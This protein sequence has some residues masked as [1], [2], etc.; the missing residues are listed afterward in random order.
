MDSP[1]QRRKVLLEI[2]SKDL[3]DVAGIIGKIWPLLSTTAVPWTVSE[4]SSLIILLEDGHREMLCSIFFAPSKR[5]HEDQSQTFPVVCRASFDQLIKRHPD[6]SA[7]I[8]S[9]FVLH[10]TRCISNIWTH[11]PRSAADLYA[12]VFRSAVS[13]VKPV[14]RMIGLIDECVHNATTLSCFLT[15]GYWQDSS[16]WTET[17]ARECCRSANLEDGHGPPA[18]HLQRHHH[19]FTQGCSLIFPPFCSLKV[20][21]SFRRPAA[22]TRRCARTS[23]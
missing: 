23:S 13:V 12:W 14:S 8:L 3:M 20:G 17:G 4:L 10:F 15:M 21:R 16:A 19:A 7:T 6:E 1:A 22:A 5:A 11:D 2:I 9:P 18:M